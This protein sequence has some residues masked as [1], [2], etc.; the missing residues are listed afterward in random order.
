MPA[1]THTF[2]SPLST[3]NTILYNL[4]SIFPLLFYSKRLI[5]LSQQSLIM[6][7]SRTPRHKRLQFIQPSPFDRHRGSSQSSA[8]MSQAALNNVASLRGGERCEHQP[9]HSI[10]PVFPSP[11][12][13][14]RC[15]FFHCIFSFPGS[16]MLML[17]CSLHIVQGHFRV[18][19]YT[20]K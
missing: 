8:G 1:H 13:C 17:Y 16:Q 19:N 4:L 18:W 10:M 5:D 15:Y 14:L 12:L 20:I 6:V 9:W 7:S 2:L 3:K 11:F